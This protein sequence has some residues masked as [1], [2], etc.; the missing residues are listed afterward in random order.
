[1]K[2]Y[3][4][5]LAEQPRIERAIKQYG[6]ASEHNFWWYQYY[7]HYYKPP[8]RNIFVETDRGALFTAYNERDNDYFVVFDPMAP[9]EFRIPILMEY[10]E[11]IFKNTSAEKI[12][13]Q[14][15]RDFRPAFLRALPK[16]CRSNPI[17]YTME[18]PIY[19]L[20]QFDTALPGG[21]YKSLRKEMHKFYR[22][23]TIAVEDAKKY[24]DKESLRAILDNWRKKRPNHERGMTGV[25]REMID[26]NFAGTDEA[27]VMTVDGKAAGFN[28]GWMIPNSERF[29]GA[30]GIHDYSVDD[31]GAMLYLEDLI[32]LKDRGYRE[33]DM[34]GGEKS[35]TAFK[36][37]FCPQSFYKTVVFSV[38]K[39][40]RL[41]R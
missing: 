15:E 33:V 16:T 12:W 36:N 19:D 41:Q 40:P 9:A 18:S 37:K 21:H 13:F 35:L 34:G 31:L 4:D 8:Q 3:E 17:Y 6:Y 38:S 29:Y 2:I 7:Q 27:R 22:E 11:W 25:Y 1:M 28:A 32:H 26:G 14:L 5:T 30:V 23:H 39:G 10:I 24:T 20:R